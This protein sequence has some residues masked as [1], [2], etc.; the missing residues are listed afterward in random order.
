M[1]AVLIQG[2]IDPAA[3]R[4]AMLGTTHCTNA[5]VERKG[6]ARIGLI[7]LS[8]PAGLAV[9]PFLEWPE[10][11]LGHLGT[12]YRIVKGGYEYNG[13]FLAAPDPQEIE[14]ALTSLKDK[15]VEALAISCVFSPVNAE[16][17]HM[18][19]DK[20]ARVFGADFPGFAFQ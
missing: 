6:L 13:A 19:R 1:D 17:E 9:P 5:I 20:A 15:E 2:R 14:E 7:R 8:A 3:I 4:H 18:A 11:I 10:D 12:H 16:Q